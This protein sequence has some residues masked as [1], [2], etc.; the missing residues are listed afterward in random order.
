[1]DDLPITYSAYSKH[2]QTDVTVADDIVGKS[3]IF[4]S[5]HIVTNFC[6]IESIIPATKSKML[7]QWRNRKLE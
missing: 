6:F 4:S 1:M 7:L 5:L 3:L 2:W